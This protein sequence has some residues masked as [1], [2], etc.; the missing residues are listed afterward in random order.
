[1]QLHEKT[2]KTVILMA[3]FAVLAIPS[4]LASAQGFPPAP[5]P[6]ATTTTETTVVAGDAPVQ[7]VELV[8]EAP[9][10]VITAAPGLQVKDVLLKR[11][12]RQ[13]VLYTHSTWRWQNLLGV[14]RVSPRSGHFTY[15]NLEHAQAVL[16]QW[17]QRSKSTH[18]QAK[19]VMRQRIVQYAKEVESWN[20]LM[21]IRSGRV[22]SARGS[23]EERYLQ[24]HRI[25]QKTRGKLSNSPHLREFLCIHHYE[26]S[27]TDSGGPYYGGLQMDLGF[28]AAYGRALLRT[29]GTADHWTPLE[30]I[31]VAERAYKSRGFYPWPNTARFCG[32]I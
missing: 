1:L 5:G 11:V 18:A 12:N 21:G 16:K 20:A 27:W 29:K 13:I 17:K 26:G 4:A 2:I 6:D 7:P 30:Q 22:L 14:R 24:A 25:R 15:A 28:Q 3:I 9:L 31:W 10:P 32:L 19:K 8:P 23:L